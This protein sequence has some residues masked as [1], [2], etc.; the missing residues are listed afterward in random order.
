MDEEGPFFLG[1]EPSL[2]DFV[3]APWAVRLWVFDHFKGGLDIPEEGRGGHD[4]KSW[5]RWRKWL[6]AIN[7]RESIK[8]TTSER[9]HY[10]PIYQR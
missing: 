6:T 4:E 7:E 10:L 5:C 1:R 9:Q 3:M 2:I 8:E